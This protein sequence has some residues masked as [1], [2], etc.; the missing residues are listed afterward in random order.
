[1]EPTLKYLDLKP[2][3]DSFEPSLSQAIHRVLD[4]GWYLLGTEVEAFE[5]EYA[6]YCDVKYCVGVAN[7]LDALTLVLQAWKE[8]NVLQE[9]DEVIVPANTYI[10]TILAVTRC[11][12]VPILV[13]PDPKTFNLD[14]TRVET[15]L[16]SKTKVILPVHLYGQ[17]ADME[18]IE[19]LSLK[20]KLKVLEDAAQGHG[21]MLK[22][23]RTGNLGDAAGFSFYPAKNLGCLGDGG[24]VTTNDKDLADCIRTIANY[25]SVKKY[26]NRYKGINSRLDELQA[27]ILRVKLQRLDVD[28]E[29]RRVIA[30]HYLAGIQNTNLHLPEIKNFDAHNFHVF[31]IMCSERDA[32]KTYLES[33]GIQSLIHYPIPPHKQ[34]AFRAWNDRSYPITESIHALELSLPV[35]PMQTP[36]E[37]EYVCRCINQYNFQS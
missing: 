13:E 3:N 23:R 28:N 10:A 33:K 15:L 18:E 2:L 9:G 1:M 24:C 31:P 34:E 8:M 37:T 11:G 7:G 27:A 32:L 16:T 35:S 17:C 14:P 22:G 12:L 36:E 30:R 29:K 21:S 6:A 19:I 4:A 5:M 26:V 25:G 20:Y